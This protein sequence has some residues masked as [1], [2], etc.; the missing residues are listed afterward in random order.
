MYNLKQL[1]G[2]TYNRIGSDSFC[3]LRALRRRF[4]NNDRGRSS[5][6]LHLNVQVSDWT[7]PDYQD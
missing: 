3:Q 5:Q 2:I 6:S 4:G 7:G 1:A